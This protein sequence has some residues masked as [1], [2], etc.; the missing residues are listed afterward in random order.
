[1]EGTTDQLRRGIL[2]VFRAPRHKY[3]RDRLLIVLEEIYQK[4]RSG[5]VSGGRIQCH[6]LEDLISDAPR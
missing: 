6:E 4:F 1:L 3:A 5:D 2:H